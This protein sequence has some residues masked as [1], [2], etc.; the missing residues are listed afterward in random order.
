MA[1]SPLRP[2]TDHCL[3]EPLPHQLA[4]QPRTT[5]S[6]HCCFPLSGLCGISFGF[7]K[8]FPTKR[9]M[10][11]VLLTRTPLYSGCP[12]LV[13]LA[14]VKRAASVDSEPGS[15]SRL[16]PFVLEYSHSPLLPPL[17][18]SQGLQGCAIGRLRF[19]SKHLT[20][21]NSRSIRFSKIYATHRRSLLKA[22][23][24][25]G[26]R[27]ASIRCRIPTYCFRDDPGLHLLR[28]TLLAYQKLADASGTPASLYQGNLKA[29]DCSGSEPRLLAPSFTALLLDYQT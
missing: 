23:T 16:N 12:F 10:I 1:V 15:N 6:A 13:R 25:Y 19:H 5:L 18:T 14:C 11:H 24:R 2:A 8:L 21:L 3:G 9:C 26:P 28:T 29:I 20:K 7:P 17:I 4:N 27:K 22:R